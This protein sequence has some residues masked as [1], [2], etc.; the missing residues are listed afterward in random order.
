[1]LN[2][3]GRIEGEDVEFRYSRENKAAAMSII[4]VEMRIYDTSIPK[5]VHYV[6]TKLVVS[7]LAAS[8]F[9]PCL[10]VYGNFYPDVRIGTEIDAQA[11]LTGA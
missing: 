4:F 10:C 11:S 9:E 3:V 7:H 8:V 2:V 6:E 5:P 1:M